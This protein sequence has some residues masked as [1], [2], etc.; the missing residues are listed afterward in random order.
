MQAMRHGSRHSAVPARALV[1][2]LAAGS[3]SPALRAQAGAPSR[4]PLPTAETTEPVPRNLADSLEGRW[5]GTHPGTALDLDLRDGVP[6]V[7]PLAGGLVEPLRER[8]DTLVVVEG[9]ASHERIARG[10]GF[11]VYRGDTLRHAADLGHPPPPPPAD[12]EPLIG[13]Y[14]LERGVLYVLERDGG[15]Y[16]QIEWRALYPLLPDSAAL[17]RFPDAGPYAGEH[18]AFPMGADG[19]ATAAVVGA[20]VF[21]RRLVG[22]DEGATFHIRPLRP[23]EELRRAALALRPPPAPPGA[24]R[25]DLV[26]VTTLDPAIRLDIRYATTNNFLGAAMYTSARAF[27][28]RPAAEA[29]ARAARRLE[30]R[31]Y[32]LLIHDA[33]R[34]WYV[35]RMFWDATP[36]SLRI[37]V[38]NPR[39]GSNHNRGCAVDLTLYDL[40][41]GRPVPTT[42]GYD[43]FSTR[44]AAF[45]PG[46]TSEQRWH[47]ALLR[48]AMEA[49]GFSVYDA[50]WWHFDFR[51][52]ARYPVLNLTFEQLA[53]AH[54]H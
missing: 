49:E 40:A 41:T 4:H 44:S 29:L 13:E 36:D 18:V 28:Q 27:L 38:A 8:R 1:L 37:F 15:L 39:V 6:W 25:P 33:Y 50:E 2:V 3:V 30:A 24:R 46:G 26:D 51:D 17:Y 19:R 54:D 53:G 23:V 43:E 20:T 32:G 35:T 22:P 48:R 10:P 34:P 7:M 5:R 11:L 21:P 12:F 31:G 9:A 47:R 42:G 52:W 14:S 45:Y 16:A